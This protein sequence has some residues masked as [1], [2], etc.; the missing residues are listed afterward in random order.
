MWHLCLSN[1]LPFHLDCLEVCTRDMGELSTGQVLTYSSKAH[2]LWPSNIS[3]LCAAVSVGTLQVWC[4]R[5]VLPRWLAAWEG[6]A[7]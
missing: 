7:T 1:Q 5:A 2:N 4:L 3:N 6:K